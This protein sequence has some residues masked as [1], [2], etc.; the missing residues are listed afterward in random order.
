[1]ELELYLIDHLCKW[2]DGYFYENW[3]GNVET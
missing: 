3:N 1:M 2:L